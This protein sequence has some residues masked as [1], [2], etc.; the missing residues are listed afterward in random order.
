M[1]KM[2]VLLFTVLACSMARA[3]IKKGDILLGANLNYSSQDYSNNGAAINPYST[4]YKTFGVGPS[5]GKAIKDNL[6][7]GLDLGYTHYSASYSPGIATT[8]N[9][10]NGGIF[11]RKYKPLGKNFYLFGE[12]ALNGNYTHN[13]QAEQPGSQPS[14]DDTHTYGFSFQLFPGLAYVLGPK[15]QL[16]AE[17]PGFCSIAYSHS[18]Q[19][20]SYTGQPD[21]YYNSH[22]FSI[23]SSFSGTNTITAGVR[24][25]IGN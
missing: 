2:Y 13:S 14:V 12:V 25:L 8:G 17:V 9:G 23:A 6:V 3:Q 15:W 19:T 10:F 18:K 22:D 20:Y 21:Q 7:L 16:E 11:L 1:K 5:F 4:S 24:Y